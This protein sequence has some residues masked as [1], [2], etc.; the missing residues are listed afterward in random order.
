MLVACV[1]V[2]GGGRLLVACVAVRGG[3]L[4]LTGVVWGVL[5]GKNAV[6]KW[7]G[8]PLFV[9]HR[10]QEE[11]DSVNSVDAASLRDPQEDADRVV[12]PKWLVILGEGGKG[13][14][15]CVEGEGRTVV[16]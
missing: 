7:R 9:R 11:I 5:A 12:N 16:K 15:Q 8:K 13:E 4:A 2:R 10:T 14:G 1:A 6:F 3:G